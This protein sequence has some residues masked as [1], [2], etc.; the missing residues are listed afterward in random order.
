M[1]RRP[2]IVA[3]GQ[4]RLATSAKA[5]VAITPGSTGTPSIW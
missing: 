1:S 3:S 5:S 2:V 4:N